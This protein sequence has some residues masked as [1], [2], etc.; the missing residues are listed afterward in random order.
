M[1]VGIAGYSGSGVTTVMALLTEDSS[2]T[3]RHS[4]GP[5]IR[6]VRV[7][8][9]R[10]ERLAAIFNPKK[11]TP[12]QMEVV[13]AGDLRPEEGGGLRKET[14]GRTRGLEALVVILRGFEVPGDREL[15]PEAELLKEL[16]GLFD[17]FCLTD[18]LPVENR[19]QRLKKEGK[20][21]TGEAL[22]LIRLREALEDGKPLRQIA[23]TV[24]ERRALQ[25][26]QFLTLFP[27]LVVAN[28]GEAGA[29]GKA[30]PGLA[31]RCAQGGIAY[32]EV[33][34]RTELDLLD[35]PAEERAPFL[36]DL[37]LAES[38]RDRLVAGIFSLLG[39]ITFFTV[40]EDEVRGWE[41]P[42]GS[43]APRA[44]GRIH[45]DLERGFIRAEVVPYDDFIAC[46]GSMA[47]ARETGKLRLEGKEYE[48][49]EGDIC[50]IRFNV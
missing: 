31:S 32:L 39:L 4:A 40:G 7:P 1:K 14:L 27:T 35:L 34:G 47:K 16:S 25:G 9:P 22:L 3:E 26:Y 41:I 11:V 28:A 2:L 46:G 19:L 17:E 6:S 33:P 42:G 5:E 48:V 21:S 18:L 20:L 13:E 10:L 30:F 36:A 29:G 49:R 15:R 50:H 37:G 44:A 8:D 12:V 38:S 43:K 45:T 23:L 24:E